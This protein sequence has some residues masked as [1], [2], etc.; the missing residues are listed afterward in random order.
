MGTIVSAR[1]FAFQSGT[2]A[3]TAKSLAD[4]GFTED[5]LKQADSAKISVEAQAIRYRMDAVAPTA[6]VGHPIAAN[7][8]E[9]IAGGSNL[10]NLR[11]I[12]QTSTATLQI[13]LLQG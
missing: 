3:G 1:A 13:S 4:L 6:S 5:Q 10:K 2:V 12:A 7:A 9:T 11:I 8:T